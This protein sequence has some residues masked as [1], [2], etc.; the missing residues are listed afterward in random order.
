MGWRNK[1]LLWPNIGLD[2]G[3]MALC[4]ANGKYKI[5]KTAHEMGHILCPGSTEVEH[6]L[7]ECHQFDA[8]QAG[9][10]I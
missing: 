10:C 7:K 4:S 5:V 2:A 1:C 8:I 3:P 6:T 9:N